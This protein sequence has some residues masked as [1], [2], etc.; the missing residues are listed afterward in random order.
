MLYAFLFTFLQF[1]NVEIQP[2]VIRV[3]TTQV[4]SDTSQINNDTL[5]LTLVVKHE[6]IGCSL[7]EQQLIMETVLTRKLDLRFPNT[8]KEVIFQK[9]QFSFVNDGSYVKSKWFRFNPYNDKDIQ[10]Y[11]LAYDLL[12]GNIDWI[13]NGITHFCVPKH[14]TSMSTVNKI[15]RNKLSF[16]FKT[17]HTFAYVK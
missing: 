2:E 4:I 8:I 7:E 17:Y 11:L 16:E 15:L 9:K 1:T 13:S 5:L 3:P 10:I 6:C 14:S 12:K